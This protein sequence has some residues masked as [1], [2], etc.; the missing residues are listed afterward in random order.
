MGRM[1]KMLQLAAQNKLLAELTPEQRLAYLKAKDRRRRQLG[2]LFG[3]L[4]DSL[5]VE[6]E[7]QQSSD[8]SS[9]S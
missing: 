3:Q 1:R 4:D 8:Q 6:Q 9:G 2:V 7:E 5:R